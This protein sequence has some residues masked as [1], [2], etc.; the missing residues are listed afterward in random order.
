MCNILG[1]FLQSDWP[2]DKPT[3]LKFNGFME[4]MLLEIDPTLKEYVITRGQYK[5]MYG[6]LDKAVYRTLL[7][8]IL[9][10]EKL[11]TQLHEWDFIMN[12]YDACTW[13]KMVNGK[14]LTIQFLIDNMYVLCKD[15][16][17]I[18]NLVHD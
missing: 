13:N 9:F 4:D 17:A 12:P 8:A 1:A 2:K 18:D 16:K 10:Y 7:G 3:Y 6:K 5:L 15:R 11:A 14:Q